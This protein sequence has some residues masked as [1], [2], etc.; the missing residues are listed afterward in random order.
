MDAKYLKALK[1]T[2]ETH[3]L[4]FLVRNASL[5]IELSYLIEK[6]FY[7]FWNKSGIQFYK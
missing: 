7:K 4:G 6:N 3:I 1:K 2:L 5:L